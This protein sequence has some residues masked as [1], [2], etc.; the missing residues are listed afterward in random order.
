MCVCLICYMK[1]HHCMVVV[2]FLLLCGLHNEAANSKF[3]NGRQ[4]RAHLG[5][6]GAQDPPKGPGSLSPG[7]PFEAILGYWLVWLK[8]LKIF[9]W[10][11]KKF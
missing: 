1:S 4:Y 10:F 3:R 8:M 2:V 5:H 6:P 7:H 11:I 9:N